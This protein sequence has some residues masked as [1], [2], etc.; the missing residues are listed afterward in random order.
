MFVKIFFSLSVSSS[1][2]SILCVRGSSMHWGSWLDELRN[3]IWP[4][5]A[6]QIWLLSEH[7]YANSHHQQLAYD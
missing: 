3:E 4:L 2:F 5:N 6:A 1:L 7:I